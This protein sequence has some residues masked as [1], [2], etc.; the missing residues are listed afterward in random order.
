VSDVKALAQVV[1]TTAPTVDDWRWLIHEDVAATIRE[2]M[3]D[4]RAR[5]D[6]H[7]KQKRSG[8]YLPHSF[9]TL[10]LRQAHL[11]SA[12]EIQALLTVASPPQE[13]MQQ[14][15]RA[16]VKARPATPAQPWVEGYDLANEV[17]EEM[18]WDD[19]PLP[20]LPQWLQKQRVVV[21]EAKLAGSVAIVATRSE[22]Y[23]A[24]TIVNTASTS[25]L[26]R[27]IGHAAA[28]AHVLFDTTLISVDGVWEHWPSAARARAFGVMLL[29][30][31]AGVRDVLQGKTDVDSDDVQRLMHRFH[32]G[33]YATTFHLKNQGFIDEERRVEI[34]RELAS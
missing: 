10:A 5:L 33:P 14:T 31:I 30:P 18:G 19:E 20:D 16:L 25:R 6:A 3:P 32:T 7:V 8:W 22:N 15:L 21:K 1:K 26:K 9:E 17:R 23:C 13:P 27:E 34:L 4:L 2:H 11:S 12:A 24:A 29:L 28:L